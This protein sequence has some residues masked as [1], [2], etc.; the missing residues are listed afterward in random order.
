MNVHK[1]VQRF[2]GH[3]GSDLVS[4]PRVTPNELGGLESPGEMIRR[5]EYPAETRSWA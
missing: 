2:F 1:G 3:V 4:C 5:S